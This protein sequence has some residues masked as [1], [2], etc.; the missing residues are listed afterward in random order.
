MGE[1]RPMMLRIS[2]CQHIL[3]EAD[4]QVAHPGAGSGDGHPGRSG[5]EVEDFRRQNP[6]DGSPTEREEDIVDVD[7]C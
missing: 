3:Q 6:S 2:G 5:R 7:E 4:L 1:T